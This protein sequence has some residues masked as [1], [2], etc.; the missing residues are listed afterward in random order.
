MGIILEKKMPEVIGSNVTDLLEP[1]LP[2]SL[3]SLF[4]C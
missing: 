2:A 1:N 4:L 3:S